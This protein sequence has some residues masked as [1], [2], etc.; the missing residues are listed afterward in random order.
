MP[1]LSIFAHS[2][3]AYFV[4]DMAALIRAAAEE[5]GLPCP[6]KNE[7]DDFGQSDWKIVLFPDEFF[8]FSPRL[9]SPKNFIA[10]TGEQPGTEHFERSRPYLA[11]ADAIWDINYDT[12]IRLSEQG[13]YC[14]FLPLLY[15]RS[16]AWPTAERSIPATDLIAMPALPEHPPDWRSRPIDLVFLGRA[17]D[18]RQEFFARHARI[19]D[20]LDTFFFF[21][22]AVSP[23]HRIAPGQPQLLKVIQNS[24]ILLNIHSGNENYFEWHR[25]VH[26]GIWQKTL[27]VSEPCSFNP[28][29][30]PDQHY[31][32]STLNDIP[33]RLFHYLGDKGREEAETTI[34]NAYTRLCTSKLSDVLL[35]LL[36]RVGFSP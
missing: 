1:P 2:R 19:F 30:Q 12:A 25:I 11:S 9:K 27:V 6:S 29:F 21:S 22:D 7:N 13:Y 35:R 26:Q 28:C 20:S 33:A 31:I 10:V 15:C 3:S 32:E 24:R 5:A 8:T 17:T 36:S 18:R 23:R 16:F 4:H 14:E 34:L